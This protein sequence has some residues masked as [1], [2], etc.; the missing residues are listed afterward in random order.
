MKKNPDFCTLEAAE[1]LV[2]CDICNPLYIFSRWNLHLSL[3]DNEYYLSVQT[4]EEP[5][6]EI[7]AG[8]CP[9][10]VRQNHLP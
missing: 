4:P 5:Q 2:F 3:R 6:V 1:N 8:C 7:R 9:Y 10:R